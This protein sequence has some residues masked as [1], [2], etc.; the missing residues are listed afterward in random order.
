MSIQQIV[1][2]FKSHNNNEIE[3]SLIEEIE[4]IRNNKKDLE[5]I[6][7]L[8]IYQLGCQTWDQVKICWPKARWKNL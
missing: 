8:H 2:L 7:S 1:D 6:K 4:K 3:N 5:L